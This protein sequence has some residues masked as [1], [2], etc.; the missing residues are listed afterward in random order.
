MRLMRY[1]L[2]DWV[3]IVATQLDGA[4]SK[5]IERELQRAQW[6]HRAAWTTWEAFTDTMARAFEPAMVVEEAR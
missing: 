3:D 5:W 1:P 2:A 4:A 6:R